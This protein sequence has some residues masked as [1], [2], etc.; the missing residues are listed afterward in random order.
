MEAWLDYNLAH[1]RT[2]RHYDELLSLKHPTANTDTRNWGEIGYLVL[3]VL[4][5]G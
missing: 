3:R 1:L 5:D 4:I 2:K